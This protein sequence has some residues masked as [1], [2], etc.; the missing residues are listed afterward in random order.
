MGKRGEGDSM[1]F[2]APAGKQPY[3]DTESPCVCA[4]TVQRQVHRGS[5]GQLSQGT[6]WGDRQH[7]A[8]DRPA[9]GDT[10]GG[11]AGRQANAVAQ[12]DQLTEQGAANAT[13]IKWNLSSPPPAAFNLAWYCTRMAI[14]KVPRRRWRLCGGHG[15]SGLPSRPVGRV[16]AKGCGDAAGPRADGCRRLQRYPWRRARTAF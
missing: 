4:G 12:I 1:F 13:L 7:A 9:G 3:K 11:Y 5:V 10:L 2:N 16:A 8:Q 14:Q 6:L 15:P